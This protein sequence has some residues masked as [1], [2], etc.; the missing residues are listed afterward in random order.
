MKLLQRLVM[1]AVSLELFAVVAAYLIGGMYAGVAAFIGASIA[2][3]AQVAAVAILVPA[4][5][6]K[7]QQ[8]FQKAW[9][10]GM[11]IRFASFLLL[12]VVM[13]MTRATFPPA[14]MAA[15]YLGTLL[16]LLFTETRFLK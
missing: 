2:T 11:A 13:V 4:M 10:V 9:V 1:V 15:G 5:Q 12:A 14:W 8:V 7:A 16:V 6:S 3:G